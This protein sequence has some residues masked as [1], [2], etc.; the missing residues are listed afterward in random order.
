MRT[1]RLTF[2]PAST[3]QIRA[4]VRFQ[5]RASPRAEIS[6]ISP[7]LRRHKAAPSRRL[8]RCSRWHSP[9]TE[10]HRCA[11]LRNNLDTRNGGADAQSESEPLWA[12]PSAFGTLKRQLNKPNE[13]KAATESSRILRFRGRS[14]FFFCWYFCWYVSN[15]EV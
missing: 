15:L 1:P 10:C 12:T 2:E 4:E 11:N 13:T 3:A 7:H 6:G 5:I 14:H 9:K 8:K